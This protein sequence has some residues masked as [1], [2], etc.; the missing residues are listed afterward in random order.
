MPTIGASM[1][2]TPGS[3]GAA[4]GAAAVVSS[5]STAG[6]GRRDEAF[7]GLG[8]RR[9]VT[10]SPASSIVTSPTPESWTIR[11]ISRIRSARLASTPLPSSDSWLPRPRIVR[12][13]GS[14]SSPKRAT[15]SSSSSLAAIPGIALAELVEVGLLL[16]LRTVG[17]QLDRPLHGRVDL[18]GRGPVASLEQVAQLVD[19]NLVALGAQHV[20]ERLRGEHLADRRRERRPAGLGADVLELGDHLVEPVALRVRAQVDVERGDE[21]GRKAVLGGPDGDPGREWRDRL[22]ADVLVDEVGGA[23]ERVDVDPSRQAEPVERAG[24]RL[25]GRPVQRRAPPGRRRRR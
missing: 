8:V 11:T 3:T 22:V 4:A 1:R 13:S 23:P 6:A 19:D 7:G 24:D 18:P 15:R 21:A 5:S 25:T 10:R 20:Q 16:G 2:I 14:A 9:T 17:D 12:R